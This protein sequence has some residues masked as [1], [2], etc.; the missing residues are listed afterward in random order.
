MTPITVSYTDRKTPLYHFIT[1]VGKGRTT[2]GGGQDHSWGR[3]IRLNSVSALN[4]V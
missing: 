2:C 1:T 4:V 3:G